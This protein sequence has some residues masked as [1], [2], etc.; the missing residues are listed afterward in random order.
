MLCPYVCS[1]VVQST[2]FVKC[3]VFMEDLVGGYH[4]NKQ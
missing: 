1:V 2:W 3:G 4:P